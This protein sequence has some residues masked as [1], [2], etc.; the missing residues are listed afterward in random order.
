MS[1]TQN[2]QPTYLCEMLERLGLD[3]AEGAVP[4]FSLSHITAFHRCEACPSKSA[5]RE[6]LDKMPTSVS[7]APDFCANADI[8]FELQVE[9][10]GRAEPAPKASDHHAGSSPT[11]NTED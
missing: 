1:N 10:P 2:R 6:W 3:P 11:D 7:F 4:H 8:L 5:C 9:H